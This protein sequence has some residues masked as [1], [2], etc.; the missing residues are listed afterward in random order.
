MELLNN[1]RSFNPQ[2]EKDSYIFLHLSKQ[3][4]II[5]KSPSFLRQSINSIENLAPNSKEF[6]PYLSEQNNSIPE[7]KDLNQER[8]SRLK[9]RTS[10]NSKSPKSK[11][12]FNGNINNNQTNFL[13]D[14]ENQWKILKDDHQNFISKNGK[15]NSFI[16]N[17]NDREEIF[18]VKGGERSISPSKLLNFNQRYKKNK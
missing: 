7:L 5:G 11:L 3:E 6:N 1:S 18:S 9:S 2:I 8:I 15:K 12:N 17:S 14:L 16:S 4:Q 13:K 10:S